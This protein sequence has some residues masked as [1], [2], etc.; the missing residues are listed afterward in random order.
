MMLRI[1]ATGQERCTKLQQIADAYLRE[2]NES[3]Y[4]LARVEAEYVCLEARLA[5]LRSTT[6][7]TAR[8]DHL[9]ARQPYSSR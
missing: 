5:E 4:P 7:S 1:G 9:S 2:Q 8:D 3:E 6:R